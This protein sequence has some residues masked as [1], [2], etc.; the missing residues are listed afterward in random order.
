[1]GGTYRTFVLA[2]Y[3]E[4]NPFGFPREKIMAWRIASIV[5][6]CLGEFAS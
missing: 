4:E 1:V 2:L 5:L 6:L 3:R